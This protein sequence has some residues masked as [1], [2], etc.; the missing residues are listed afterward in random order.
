MRVPRLCRIELSP[1]S[2]QSDSD[3]EASDSFRGRQRDP[4]GSL[5]LAKTHK[6]GTETIKSMLL[7]L[8]TLNRYFM[9]SA[10]D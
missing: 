8:A 1:V 4:I 7:D 9:Q 10:V 6:T 5:A 3:A 2:S